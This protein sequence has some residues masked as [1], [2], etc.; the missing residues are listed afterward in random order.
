MPRWCTAPATWPA[1]E[2]V[3]ARLAAVQRTL[4]VRYAWPLLWLGMRIE[5]DQ[6]TRAR[7]RRE[8]LPAQSAERC[9]DLTAMAA[10]LAAPTPPARGYLALVRAEQSRAA[11]DADQDIWS[12]AVA[13][14]RQAGEPYPLAYALLR[15]AE[16]R[17]TLGERQSA[18]GN[19]QQAHAIASQIGAEP[20]E[21]EAAALA[22]RARLSLPDGPSVGAMPAGPLP[23]AMPDGIRPAASG[24]ASTAASSAAD[25]LGRFGLTA[26]E[27]E[28]LLLAVGRS[29]PQIAQTLFISPKTASV[30]VSNILA[31][32]GVSGRSSSSRRAGR[33][34]EARRPAGYGCRT[35]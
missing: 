4:S 16:V 18:T 2:K 13:A 8:D 5:A 33:K 19:V 24:P 15:L 22:I 10:E 21:Q 35:M 3:A 28:V 26:R 1:R 32:L 31:K 14:W 34:S 11:G 27:R 20:I 17:C 12:S 7:D 6:A 29:N 9:R 25:E 30:H 23:G